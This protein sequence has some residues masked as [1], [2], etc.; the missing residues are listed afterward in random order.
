VARKGKGAAPR[1]RVVTV[2]TLLNAAA[3]HGR[4][5]EPDHECGDLRE[6]ARAMWRELGPAARAKIVVEFEDMVADWY[7]ADITVPPLTCR[8]C[9]G[10]GDGC[11][12]CFRHRV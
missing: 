10:E 4:I 12:R 1:A 7:P 6:L 8:A 5:S 11:S 9:N 3:A 2:E